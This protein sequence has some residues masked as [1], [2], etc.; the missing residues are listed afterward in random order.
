MS[1]K[2]YVL[3]VLSI[4]MALTLFQTV[5][6]AEEAKPAEPAKAPTV[7]ISGFVD[8]IATL[9]FGDAK[10]ELG[11]SQM[12]LYLFGLIFDGEVG[13]FGFHAQINLT[14]AG[15]SPGTSTTKNF[16]DYD[17]PLWLEEGY[18]YVN[19]YKGKS[20]ESKLKLGSVYNPFGLQGD[21]S[22]YYAG[23]YYLGLSL[24]ADYGAVLDSTYKVNDKMS[25]NFALA[26]Y[27][28]SDHHNGGRNGGFG[29]DP[30]GKIGG[31]V[32]TEERDT[33]VGRLAGTFGAGPATITPGA[34]IMAGTIRTAINTTS[35]DSSQLNLE[36]DLTVSLKL[37]GKE[38]FIQIF[39]EYISAQRNKKNRD[40]NGDGTPEN[41]NY[42]AFVGGLTINFLQDLKSAWLSSMNFHANYSRVK[43]HGNTIDKGPEMW[44][45]G[46][47]AGLSSQL[48]ANL[49]Y[50]IGR[51]NSALS[52]NKDY[53]NR[54][55][56]AFLIDLTYK[57]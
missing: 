50:V 3:G 52:Y 1:K 55:D 35:P 29:L 5:S 33:F 19:L 36:L 39:G 8:L 44:I 41:W 48:T 7:T 37:L 31:V 23:H 49:E 56:E 11:K 21:N 47:G 6:Y 54:F 53:K 38:N 32:Y 16:T 51:K 30:E 46:L 14:G 15:H 17:H 4:L 40:F 25:F 28:V 43:Y 22:W 13:K 27:L 2:F 45:F 18:I 26:Y 42:N 57:F 34:S 10:T 20:L 12:N 9:R 24:D